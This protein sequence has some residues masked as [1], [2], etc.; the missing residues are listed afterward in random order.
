MKCAMAQINPTVGDIH[1]NADRIIASIERAADDGMDLVILPEMAVVGYPAKD[2]LLKSAFIDAN[3]NA[4]NK[5]AS[6]TRSVTAVVG[7]AARNTAGSG[8]GLFNSAAV[9]AS[10][11]IVATYHKNLLPTYDVFDEIR[12]FEPG[13][14][15]CVVNVQTPNGPVPVGITICEDIWNDDVHFARRLY[16]RDPAAESVHAGAKMLVNIGASPFAL[17][18]PARR[19]VLFATK[20]KNLGVPLVSVN[21]VGGNDDLVFDGSA[22]AFDATGHVIARAKAFDEDHQCVDLQ[23]GHGHVESLPDDIDNLYHA[24]VL[25]TRDYV[26]KCGF[27][28]AVIGL[29]GGIDSAVTAAI[30]VAALGSNAVHFVAMPSRF[31][32]DHSLTDAQA[33]ADALNVELLRIPIHK[34]HDATEALLSPVFGDRPPGIAE[35]NLQA[36]TR[37]SILMALSNKFGWLLLTTG[38]KSELAVGYCTLYG[39]MCGGLAVLSDVPKTSVYQLAEFINQQTNPGVIP[40]NS[41]TKPPSA[42]LRENQADQDSLPP[43]DQLDAILKRYVETEVSWQ[44]IVESGFDESIVRDVVKLVDRNEYKRKQAPVGLKV[45]SR[46]FGTGRRMPIAAKYSW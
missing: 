11:S 35:E 16:D 6:A 37:G 45:T 15:P 44:D 27:S 36:R 9:L 21:Q 4:L 19:D 14:S 7:F 12:Y 20:A 31:S 22:T 40:T 42:E 34:I 17:S 5:I 43:Y 39:D 18:K 2:L 24:L 3:L 8:K 26:S 46:A 41:I 1:G 23:S 29:S 25:G 32:S 33:L 28:A 10:G 30:A 38:N 13:H